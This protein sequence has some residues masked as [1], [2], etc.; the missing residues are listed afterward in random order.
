MTTLSQK[1]TGE[2]TTLKAECGEM[3]HE[4]LVK[5]LPAVELIRFEQAID[6]ELDRRGA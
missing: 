6:T 5:G 1:T 3:I 2:L 4:L